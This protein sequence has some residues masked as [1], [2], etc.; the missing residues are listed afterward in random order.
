MLPGITGAANII[1][2][3][4]E[5]LHMSRKEILAGF[6][7]EAKDQSFYQRLISS[8]EAA[9]ESGRE[10]FWEALENKKF[11]SFAEVKQFIES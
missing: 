2:Y 8:I 3:I 5:D 6:I 4:I 11:H 10:R 1:S 7:Q 9:N